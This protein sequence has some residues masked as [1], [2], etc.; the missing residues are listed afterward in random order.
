MEMYF[1]VFSTFGTTE[2][3]NILIKHSSKFL[4]LFIFDL[5]KLT[6][7]IQHNYVCFI[8]RV[9]LCCYISVIFFTKPQTGLDR[10]VKKYFF[11]SQIYIHF[12]I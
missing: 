7:S 2:R 11:N 1:V 9:M 8:L 12:F 6:N 10:T 5:W 3:N 4:F